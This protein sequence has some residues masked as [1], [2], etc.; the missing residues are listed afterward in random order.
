MPLVNI[1]TCPKISF[2]E[3]IPVNKIK[4]KKYPKYKHPCAKLLLFLDYKSN[5]NSEKD[6]NLTGLN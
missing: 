3:L 4:N 5:R 6:T 1:R 2:R